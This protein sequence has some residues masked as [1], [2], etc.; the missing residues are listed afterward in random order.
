MS[1]KLRMTPVTVRD[2]YRTTG[3]DQ[4]KGAWVDGRFACPLY[5]C[6]IAWNGL[7][8]HPPSKTLGDKEELASMADE[9]CGEG[10]RLGFEV[11]YNTELPNKIHGPPRKDEIQWTKGYLD[12]VRLRRHLWGA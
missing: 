9:M 3:H 11:G 1:G 2:A 6:I 12:G 10:Y 8:T 5:A 4:G 7:N